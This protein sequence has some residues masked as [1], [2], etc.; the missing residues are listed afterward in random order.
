MIV[1]IVYIVGFLLT[2]FAASFAVARYCRC[3]DPADPDMFL[4]DMFLPVVMF[5]LAWPIS[6]PLTAAIF[7]LLGIATLAI[8]M[9][10]R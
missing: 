9:A 1:P 6:V 10:G 2:F 8:K 3:D 4:P 5:T 7:L